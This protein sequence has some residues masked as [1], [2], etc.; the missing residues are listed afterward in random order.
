MA[1]KSIS[2]LSAKR[3]IALWGAFAISILIFAAFFSGERPDAG[4][5]PHFYWINLLFSISVLT[6]F[7]L[8]KRWLRLNKQRRRLR[9]YYGLITIALFIPVTK[10]LLEPTLLT[11]L[12]I[13]L[14]PLSLLL[15]PAV[16]GL[17]LT[18][19]HPSFIDG[20][21]IPAILALLAGYWNFWYISHWT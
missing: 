7:F 2:N 21:F 14:A 19:K 12:V 16:I 10:Y 20:R 9:S 1:E 6:I 15:V 3:R 4:S 17:C 13:V 11:I 8:E 18:G 5:K